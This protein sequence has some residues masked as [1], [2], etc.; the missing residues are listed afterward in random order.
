MFFLSAKF[1]N[2]FTLTAAEDIALEQNEILYQLATLDGIK[3]TNI[4]MSSYTSIN[5]RYLIH[6]IQ[7]NQKL[8]HVFH[9]L[10]ACIIIL[11]FTC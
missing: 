4:T 2:S 9:I 7:I 8:Y 10:A 3:P 11:S 5:E 6:S 1:Y